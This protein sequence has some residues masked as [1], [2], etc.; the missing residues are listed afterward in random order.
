MPGISNIPILGWFFKSKNVQASTTDLVVLVTASIVDP[1][2]LPGPP[3]ELPKTVTP[4]L[5][6]S[7]FD[8]L[9]PRKE[10]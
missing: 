5:D 9:M 2:A 4:Y 8:T 6:K 7:K 10:N 1:L 3:P